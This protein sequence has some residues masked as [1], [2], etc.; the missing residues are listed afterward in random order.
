REIQTDEFGFGLQGLLSARS[1]EL[2]GILNGIEEQEWNPATDVHLPSHY[3][4]EHLADKQ[5][6]KLALQRTLTLAEDADA[7]LLGVVSRLTHQKGLDLLLEIAP[8]LLDQGCQ[9]AVLGSG[10]SRFEHGFTQLAQE[11][12]RQ[13]SFTRGYNEPRSHQIMAAADIFIMPSRFEPCGLNQMYG[14]RY[15]TPPVV[16]RTGGLADSI[17]DS[18]P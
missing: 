16:S 10:D 12:P 5:Q 18:T 2:H 4:A 17:V 7:P 14:L 8:Q 11:Y 9:L 3:D 6:V 15:G 13:A 1:A